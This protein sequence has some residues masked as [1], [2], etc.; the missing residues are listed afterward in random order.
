MT[1]AAVQI[2]FSNAA[3]VAY[4][5]EEDSAI[6]LLTVAGQYLG[7]AFVLVF[8]ALIKLRKHYTNVFAPSSIFLV[9]VMAV[10]AM[11]A[12]AYKVSTCHK[13]PSRCLE[14]LPCG[15]GLSSA[16]TIYVL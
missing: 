5:I 7:A 11:F 12:L 2:C 10:S 15:K 6:A 4:P 16:L 14:L 8:D 1:A 9:A 13:R 3:E